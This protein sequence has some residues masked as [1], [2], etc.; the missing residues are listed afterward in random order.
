M[1]TAKPRK[2]P[3]T[4]TARKAATGAAKSAAKSAAK[5]TARTAA[6]GA[7]KGAR[8][9][10]AASGDRIGRGTR[11]TEEQVALLLDTVVSSPTAK[12][13]FE[14]VAR[15]IGKSAGTVAQKY[16]NL[17]KASGSPAGAKRA[18]SGGRPA[19]R[20]PARSAGRP[21]SAGARGGLPNATELRVLTVD[22]L[23]GLA[24]RVKTEI[25]RRRSE[26]DAASKALKG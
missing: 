10:V 21:A 20:G 15:Q 2:K 17:Q 4:T 5:G 19:G 16:Y 7:A 26:L 1:A 3:A 24:M 8:K 23:T 6:K 18:S 11:W 13:A 22:D 14:V 12:E 9:T 25:D